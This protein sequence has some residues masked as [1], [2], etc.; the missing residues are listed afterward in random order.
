[1]IFVTVGN[2]KFESLVKHLD[3][4]K[5][6]NQIKDKIIIQIGHGN[7]EP[8]HCEFFKFA[9]NLTNYYNKADVVIGHG[10]PGTVFEVLRL[11][12]KLIALANTNR[13]DPRHQVEFLSA[14]S[15]ETNSLIYCD[16]LSKLKHKIKEARLKTFSTYQ[17]PEC[18]MHNL[19]HSFLKKKPKKKSK[20][21]SIK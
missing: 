15:K 9:P 7:F 17:K 8:K 12:K 18:Q 4:L 1:L 5:E 11:K 3:H 16:D 13:T 14:I 10:G 20:I 21:K 2:G 6:T 19:I